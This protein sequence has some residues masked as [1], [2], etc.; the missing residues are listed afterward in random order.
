VR[1]LQVAVE[2]RAQLEGAILHEDERL[3]VLN[4]PPGLAVHGGSGIRLG[5]I[6]LLRAQ[7]P[8][9]PYLELV[10]RLDRETSGCL[11]IA[12]KRSELRALHQ[13]L[14]ERGMDKRYLALVEGAWPDHIGEISAPL[15]RGREHKGGPT[16]SV[17]PGGK[18]STTRVRVCERFADYTLIEAHPTTGRT[19]QIRVHAQ[20]A[21]HPILGDPR[22]GTR[23]LISARF[24]K[25]FGRMY[26]HASQITIPA[27]GSYAERRFSAPLD[28]QFQRMIDKIK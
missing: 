25:G 27:V 19:H 12:K 21:G 15:V 1:A 28:D 20:F 24:G 13:I 5:V 6:E 14:R 9:L 11:L 26:L 8:R 4:K 2:Q 10:H 17:A 3:L 18:L 22:Y 16:A 23:G 7:R